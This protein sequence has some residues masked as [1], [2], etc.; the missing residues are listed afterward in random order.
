MGLL[1]R[2]GLRVPEQ[3]RCIQVQR[4]GNPEKRI[5]G[6]GALSLFDEIDAP[7]AVKFVGQFELVCAGGCPLPLTRL[8]I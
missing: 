4:E 2:F 6:R 7:F 5:D 3:I 8:S 1:Q